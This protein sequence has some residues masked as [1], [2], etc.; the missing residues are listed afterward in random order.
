M[1]SAVR[2]ALAV[3]AYLPPRFVRLED[4]GGEDPG[5]LMDSAP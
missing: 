2:A 1:V 5:T 4:R 3:N